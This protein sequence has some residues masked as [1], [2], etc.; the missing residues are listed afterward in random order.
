MDDRA[1]PEAP[2]PLPCAA[3]VP[4]PGEPAR[5]GFTKYDGSPHW[6]Y[7]LT[8]VG[9]DGYG[10]WLG[11]GPGSACARPGR[12]LVPGVAWVSLVPHVGGYVS[13]FNAP[14]GPLSAGIYIDLAS[15]PQWSRE[16]GVLQV[17]AVDLDLD[18][19]R[20]FTG[21]CSIEDVEEFEEHRLAYGYPE[22]LV[23]STRALADRLYQDVV[24]GVEPY[25]R[26]GAQWL[27]H[28]QRALTAQ[29]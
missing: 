5:L 29:K 16:A 3:V 4:D 8:V 23:S 27:Q 14:G 17:D 13:T 18:V 28:W 11:G 20:R 21:V 12:T 1:A 19:V 22:A 10:V 7:E 25:G 15:V 6:R 26:V 2:A 24:A 9:I